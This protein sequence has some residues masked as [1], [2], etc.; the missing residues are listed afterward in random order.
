MTALCTTEI[1]AF[2]LPRTSVPVPAKS[3][4]AEPL[5]VSMETL[6]AIG[7]PSSR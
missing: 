5:E 1:G 6:S 7:E 3:K 2:R 4:V